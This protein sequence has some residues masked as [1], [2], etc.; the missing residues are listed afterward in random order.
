MKNE[1]VRRT[2]AEREIPAVSRRG[3]YKGG[4]TE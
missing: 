1:T 2:A 3:I 4:R